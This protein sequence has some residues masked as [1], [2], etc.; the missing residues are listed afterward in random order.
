MRIQ[1]MSATDVVVN[2]KDDE[3]GF[4]GTSADKQYKCSFK[5]FKAVIAAES[6]YKI[7]GWGVEVILKK[8]EAEKEFWTS[9]AASGKLPYV[10]IDWERWIDEDDDEKPKQSIPD[11]S[12]MPDM[13][14]MGGMDMPDMSN[15]K[16]PEGDADAEADEKEGEN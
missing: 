10:K 11:F 3:F 6:R 5:T 8:A 4:A 16:L 12:N 2:F 9:V 1:V 14:G 13:G 15:F 7:Q